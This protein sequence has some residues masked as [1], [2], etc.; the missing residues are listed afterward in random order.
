MNNDERIKVMTER[1]QQRFA[2]QQ[3]MIIDDSEHHRGHA[4]SQGGA[5]HFTVR[6]ASVHFAGKSRVAIHREI[7]QVLGELIPTE[8]HALRIEILQICATT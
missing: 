7:Y 6:I 1:L 2:P 3:L 8:V 5:G 4:G